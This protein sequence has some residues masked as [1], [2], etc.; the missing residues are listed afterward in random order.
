MPI[1]GQESLNIGIINQSTGSDDLYTAFHKVQNNFTKLFS[2]SSSYSTFRSGVGITTAS[3]VTSGIITV[4]NTGVTQLIPGSGITMSGS[5]GNIIISVSGDANGN[6]VAGVT[7][8]GI[9]SNTLNVTSG[10]VISTGNINVELDNIA[11]SYGFTPGQYTAPTITV[12]EYGRIIQINDATSVGTVQSIAVATEGEGLSVTG[13]PITDSGTITIKNTGVTRLNAGSGIAISGN[14]GEITI[15]S[16]IQSSGTV[17]RVA[18]LSSS[19]VVT[20]SPITSAG[21][22]N[23]EPKDDL[24]LVGNLTANK[25]LFSSDVE[26]ENISANANIN[27]VDFDATGNINIDGNAVISG[28]L[29][30]GDTNI[31]GNLIVTGDLTYTNV[32]SMS[33][34][35]PLIELGGGANNAALSSNDGKDRG[36]LLH[37][38]NGSAKDAF[39]GWDNS[40]NEFV[41]AS[42]VETTDNVIT[43]NSLGNIRVGNITVSSIET[44]GNI[45]TGN[46][47]LDGVL[48]VTGN[49]N[50]GNLG[51]G[52]DI[53]AAS[54]VY[55]GN[56]STSG[57]M[58][59]S[60]NAT[61][62]NVNTATIIATSNVTASTFVGILGNGTSNIRIPVSSSNV[63]ISVAG[64]AN[65]VT[66]SGTGVNVAGTLNTGTGNANVGN[67]GVS[68]IINVTG[69]ITSGAN[70]T[71]G[72]LLGRLANGNSNVNIPASNGNV[73]ISVTGTSNV[74]VVTPTGVN[75]AGTFNIGTGNANVGNIGATSGVFTTVTGSLTTGAQP[76]ITSTGTL[77]SL[78]VTGAITG[79]SFTGS[80]SNGTSN[81][82]IPTA[83]GNINLSV[84]GTPNVLIVTGTGANIAGTLRS[85]GNAN[86]G[87]IGATYAITGATIATSYIQAS[88]A[89]AY[90]Q[91]TGATSSI[92]IVG[93]NS[94]FVTSNGV[95][96][97]STIYSNTGNAAFTGTVTGQSF[98]F[99]NTSL[100]G[101]PSDGSFCLD[102]GNNRIGIYYSGGWH[103]ASLTP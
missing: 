39:I 84:N 44:V 37:Y 81:V 2:E 94:Y 42:Q 71:A 45:S 35:D 99:G 96:I 29:S 36:Q 50:V 102:A 68:G 12:D 51:S 78:A 47:S 23:I 53:T 85:T 89:S 30:A 28:T 70:V 57:T 6:I 22:I 67:L 32:V 49:A 92:Q 19:F 90:V 93:A 69:N 79:A 33:V 3:N 17:S 103:Y 66:V 65:I 77:T 27:G 52:G 16:I 72:N 9:D 58:A 97:T 46:L 86:V 59:V 21:V 95:S 87:N 18:I 7:S 62:G 31:T 11:S 48:H 82:N 54:N 56:I 38:Y 1:S 43:V 55:A 40:N 10:P 13:S 14:T 64:N 73:T 8:I 98:V 76:N 15:S 75:V 26:A 80:H 88:G 34:E 20:G 100:T 5:T 83:N 24:T 61:I 63:V 91:A 60:G 74:I 25:G 41:L 101:S 4:T